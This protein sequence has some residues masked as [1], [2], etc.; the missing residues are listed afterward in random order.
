MHT[1]IIHQSSVDAGERRDGMT[2]ALLLFGTFA[3]LL[4]LGV[5]IAFSLGVASVLTMVT[6]LNVNLSTIAQSVFN[7]MNTTTLLS[8]PFFILAGNIMGK[9]GISRQIVVFCNSLVG[10][11][12]GGVSVALV[13]ACTFFAALSGSGPATVV[14]V[15]MVMY[16]IMVNMGYPPR[17]VAGLLSVSGGLGP[18]IPPSIIMVVYATLTG[19]SISNMFKVGLVCGIYTTIAL[20]VMVF[21]FAHREQWPRDNRHMTFRQL[22]ASFVHA[23]PALILPVIIL[24]GIYSGLTTAV[25][26][27]SVAVV[28]ALVVSFTVYKGLKLKDLPGIIK[29]S[30][31]SS[32]MVLFIVGTST[33]FTWV[34]TFSGMSKSIIALTAAIG[35]G[36]MTF[37]AV[38]MVL[39]LIFGLFMEG[40]SICLLFVPVLWPVA[41]NFGISALQFGIIISMGIVVGTMTPPVAVNLFSAVSVSKLSLGEVVKGQMPF[42][43]TFLI[44]YM[45]MVF[46][47][48]LYL[49]IV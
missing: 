49:W 36:K 25:E 10:N 28:Y 2:T 35:L 21:I 41:Q 8:I 34:F 32:A 13:L 18:I 7:G 33:A 1:G 3:V 27:S 37:L 38:V 43:I 14:S 40:T 30:A 26:V 15:G 31:K 17:R 44:M 29:E 5:P 24:G 9:G 20:I 6:E 39:T 47:P 22:A 11:I 23:L 12:R 16:E 48:M 4:I 19:T 45:V 46:C 42:F